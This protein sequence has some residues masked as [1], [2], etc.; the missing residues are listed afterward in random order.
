MAGT[1][2]GYPGGVFLCLFPSRFVPLNQRFSGYCR[3]GPFPGSY[4][5]TNDDHFK[6]PGNAGRGHGPLLRGTRSLRKGRASIPHQIFLSHPPRLS[7]NGFS[8][9]L[10]RVTRPPAVS[11]TKRWRRSHVCLGSGA[12]SCPLAHS[13]GRHGYAGSGHEPNQILKRPYIQLC[14]GQKRAALAVDVLRLCGQRGRG[15]ERF[16]PPHDCQSI[17]GESGS[18]RL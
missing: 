2:P 13:V 8:S 18:A 14:I 12:G 1:P 6:H 4:M 15:S 10:T 11:K 5:T 9:I 17:A 7:G 16:G 3:S